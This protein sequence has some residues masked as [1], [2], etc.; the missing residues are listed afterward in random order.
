MRPAMWLLLGALAVIAWM[1]FGGPRA[2]SSAIAPEALKQ[3]RP[4][5]PSTAPSAVQSVAPARLKVKAALT[6]PTAVEVRRALYDAP[7]I[8]EAVRKLRASG[9]PD[10]KAWAAQLMRE[11]YG[12]LSKEQ[13]SHRVA[14]SNDSPQ[15][16][17][18]R[19]AAFEELQKRCDGF[20]DVSWPARRE[21]TAELA[22]SS[23]VST[24]TFHA[25]TA[26]QARHALGD[27]RW[28]QEESKLVAQALYSGDPLIK[29]E[30]FWA[31]YTAIDK[32]GPG[33]EERREAL[34]SALADQLINR[35]L[36]RFEQL[37]Q[38]AVG[39]ICD[40]SG[41]SNSIGAT[42]NRLQGLYLEAF[43]QRR[44]PEAILAIR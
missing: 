44:P 39:A 20:N 40:E 14:G 38:C 16:E 31:L 9:S 27:T 41:L 5:E 28:N 8:F 22:A 34:L 2:P 23:H 29:R 17:A 35:P 13:H 15:V 6:P 18:L 1:T 32:N 30:A 33:G 4:I 24:S 19:L 43:A 37:A 25:L 36:S 26:L 12:Y 42:P 11:C 10:E 21:A 7:N 3:A